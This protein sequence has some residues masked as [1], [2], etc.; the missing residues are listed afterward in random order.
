MRAWAPRGYSIQIADSPEWIEAST[1]VVAGRAALPALVGKA[2]GTVAA[3][4][5]MVR[6]SAPGAAVGPVIER[7]RIDV[8][9]QDS[10]AAY[11]AQFWIRD[12]RQDAEFILPPSSR[13]VEIYVQGKRLPTTPMGSANGDT[14]IIVRRPVGVPS[15]CVIEFRYRGSMDKLEPPTL[16][17]GVLAGD[18][19]WAIVGRP[20]SVVIVPRNS[21]GNWSPGAL[22]A[23]LGI[24]AL[25]P[26]LALAHAAGEPTAL[27][28]KNDLGNVAVYQAPR[29]TWTFGWSVAAFAVACA[30]AWFGRRARGILG[31]LATTMFVVV[32]FAVPQP[33]ALMTFALLPGLIAFAALALVYR[34]TRL[35][36][37]RRVAYAVGFA[38]TG[39][40]LVRP[41]SRPPEPIVHE[42]AAVPAPAP[43]SH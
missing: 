16:V 1:E 31:L 23:T 3:P 43:S 35:R 2:R 26:G 39:S 18:L 33:A 4:V 8:A 21:P 20:G 42:T 12:W 6:T 24:D 30:L 10:D 37:R 19:T 17:R 29:S 22:L 25:L 14:R 36:Y 32:L 13:N 40:S 15:L 7:V 28:R 27:V 34:W 11:R 9:L 41:P 38:R 5:I